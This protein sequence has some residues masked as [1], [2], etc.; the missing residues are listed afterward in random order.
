MGGSFKFFVS[1][2]G[3]A[4]F[5]PGVRFFPIHQRY[6]LGGQ[7]ELPRFADYGSVRDILVE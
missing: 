3:Q 5:R 2:F 7:G 1:E 6:Q 4:K